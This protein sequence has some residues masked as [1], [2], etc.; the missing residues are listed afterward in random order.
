MNNAEKIIS[1]LF[2]GSARQQTDVPPSIIDCNF[3]I[4]IIPK[5]TA[6]DL[7]SDDLPKASIFSK[8]LLPFLF[9]KKILRW[10]YD[11]VLSWA[12]SRFGTAALAAI[13]FMESS[14]FPIPPDILQIALSIER[15]KRSFY[16][17]FVSATASV[18]GA[19]LG[20]YIGLALWDVLGPYFVPNIISEENMKKV[21]V[22]FDE[23]G[24]L[25]LFAAAFTPIPFKAFTITSGIVAMPLPGVIFASLIGRSLRF[26]IV[27]GLI[28]VFG[29]SVKGWIDKYFGLLTFLFLLLL[30]LGFYAIKYLL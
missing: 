13:S 17:A 22:F 7:M 28:Y 6:R 29:P 10:L 21:H 16:Y 25:A 12:H 15:P 26:F 24:F 11:W 4:N 3:T 9:L 20:W 30:V 14:F 19:V 5:I 8:L 23:Y 2:P 27:A 1:A 18:A